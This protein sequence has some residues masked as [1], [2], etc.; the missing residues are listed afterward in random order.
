MIEGT[1]LAEV[2]ELFLITREAE[3]FYGADGF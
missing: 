1:C 3:L 2:D